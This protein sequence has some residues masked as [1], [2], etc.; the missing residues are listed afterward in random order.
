MPAIVLLKDVKAVR[1]RIAVRKASEVCLHFVQRQNTCILLIKCGANI[2][3]C[4]Y[5]S[6][7][8]MYDGLIMSYFTDTI[9][10]FS[11]NSSHSFNLALNLGG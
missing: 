1:C 5:T 2:I 9:W 11:V 10:E 3:L 6:I 8:N 7:F 4:G